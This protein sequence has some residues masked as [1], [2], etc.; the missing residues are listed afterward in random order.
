ML[1]WIMFYT[2]VLNLTPATWCLIMAPF[3]TLLLMV[4]FARNKMAFLKS[5][6][7]WRLVGRKWGQIGAVVLIVALVCYL[8]DAGLSYL[9]PDYN[10]QFYYLL[11]QRTN[12]IR[13]ETIRKGLVRQTAERLGETELR[14]K[15]I[16]YTKE[17]SPEQRLPFL[18]SVLGSSIDS[19]I[20]HWGELLPVTADRSNNIPRFSQNTSLPMD[21]PQL[22][23]YEAK[24]WERFWPKLRPEQW[25]YISKQILDIQGHESLVSIVTNLVSDMDPAE[26]IRLAQEMLSLRY[27]GDRYIGLRLAHEAGVPNR[28][29]LFKLLV[30]GVT[31]LRGIIWLAIWLVVGLTMLSQAG[32]MKSCQRLFTVQRQ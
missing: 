27:Q 9:R 21:A 3:V 23:L 5:E 8:A 29:W 2:V 22:R 6:G 25:Q 10:R 12:K 24:D 18:M 26:S 32:R 31:W 1:Y 7:A 15:A 13:S 11:G 30:S 19:G 16:T 17:V 4:V 20:I 28:A 14:D